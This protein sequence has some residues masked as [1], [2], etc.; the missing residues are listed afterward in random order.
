MGNHQMIATSTAGP[1]FYIVSGALLVI[2]GTALA[3]D[4]RGLGT[5]YIRLTLR[6]AG[7]HTIRR[8]RVWYAVVAFIGCL[9]VLAGL[10][11]L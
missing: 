6:N 9:L 2:F 5:R 3:L 1:A 4:L 10:T 11:R 8:Y 7:D